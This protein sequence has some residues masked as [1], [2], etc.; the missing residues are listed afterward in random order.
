MAAERDTDAT[1]V[2]S[3]SPVT[4]F[5]SPPVAAASASPTN[6]EGPPPVDEEVDEE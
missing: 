2:G 6:E 3:G 1:M 4:A 5:E